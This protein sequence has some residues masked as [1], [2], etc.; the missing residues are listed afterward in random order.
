MDGSGHIISL[1]GDMNTAMALWP[2]IWDGVNALYI[3]KSCRVHPKYRATASVF[4][5]DQ[6]I[7]LQENN[8]ACAMPSQYRF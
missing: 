6:H 3:V 1:K 7:T 4:R 5:F 8:M 2:D